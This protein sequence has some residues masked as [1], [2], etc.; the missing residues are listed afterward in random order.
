M[1]HRLALSLI[2]SLVL[3]SP[4]LEANAAPPGVAAAER[5]IT[6]A[7]KV[8]EVDA[9]HG[10]VTAVDQDGDT[11]ELTVAPG[12]GVNLSRVKVGDT[13]RFTGTRTPET[14]RAKISKVELI[15]R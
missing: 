9:A 6:M 12:S 7:L 3:A 13:Y 8:T 15:P 5:A 10:R 4:I 14:T 1:T 11:W 2:A